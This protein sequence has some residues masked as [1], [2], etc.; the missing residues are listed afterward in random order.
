MA[1]GVSP[2]RAR[3]NV[4][5]TAVVAGLAGLLFG[6]DAGIIASALLFVQP[7]FMPSSFATGLVVA[8]VP[9]GAAIGAVSAGPVSDRVGRRGPI[10]VAAALFVVG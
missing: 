8:T 2:E 3:R 1:E 7:D 10:L 9:I 6:Y 5:L 4:I